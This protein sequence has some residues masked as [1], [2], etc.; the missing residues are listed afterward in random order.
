MM[1][2]LSFTVGLIGMGIIMYGKRADNSNA[3]II[4]ALLLVASY[5]IGFR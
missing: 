4:G 3:M 5:F 1:L 2:F